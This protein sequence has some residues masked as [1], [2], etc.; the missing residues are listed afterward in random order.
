MTDSID[1]LLDSVQSEAIV[2]LKTSCSGQVAVA[3]LFGWMQ[4]ARFPRYVKLVEEGNP[5]DLMQLLIPEGKSLE[6]QLADIR[7]ELRNQMLDASEDDAAIEIAVDRAEDIEKVDAI[8][9][10]AKEHLQALESEL[11]KGN[12]SI[13]KVDKFETE[14]TG[15]RHVTLNSLQAWAFKA[16]GK[17]I[18]GYE[19][20]PQESSASTE[21]TSPLPLIENQWLVFTPD[22][23]VPWSPTMTKSFL[24]TFAILLEQYEIA[25][26]KQFTDESGTGTVKQ[27]IAKHLQMHSLANPIHGKYLSGMSEATIEL[28]IGE[29]MDFAAG[30]LK[31]ARR[32][33]RT[34]KSK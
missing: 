2:D 33:A 15:I 1:R 17:A 5:L 9:Q 12:Q 4:G 20:A 24:I 25:T 27:R 16:L 26:K 6:T 7:E 29:V 3:K 11:D 28:R 8:I 13:L 19:P 30:T 34:G 23:K 14:A 31:T 10:Q 22:L 32:K 18:D 21:Q